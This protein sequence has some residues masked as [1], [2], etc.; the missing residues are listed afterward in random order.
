MVKGGSILYAVLGMVVMSIVVG[1]IYGEA[2]VS[3]EAVRTGAVCGASSTKPCLNH[4]VGQ[5]CNVANYAGTCK[6][7]TS[8]VNVCYCKI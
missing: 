8:S 6:S 5:G 1:A 2:G 3:S 7:D 4:Y